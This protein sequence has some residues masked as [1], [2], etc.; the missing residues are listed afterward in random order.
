MPDGCKYIINPGITF[1]DA[2]ER[3]SLLR[4]SIGQKQL[5]IDPWV[6]EL[7]N[8]LTKNNVSDRLFNM[9]D[10][11][12]KHGKNPVDIESTIE[13]LVAYD[14]LIPKDES[15][16]NGERT[17]TIESDRHV[18]NQMVALTAKKAVLDSEK[19]STLGRAFAWIFRVPLIIAINVL[20]FPLLIIAI[21][22]SVAHFK[23]LIDPY[24]TIYYSA[25]CMPILVCV[26]VA[27]GLLHE[28][29][30][31][32]AAVSCGCKVGE[33]GIGI[34]ITSIALYTNMND[35]NISN[36]IDR[37]KIDLGGITVECLILDILIIV[38]FL[39]IT[40]TYISL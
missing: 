5:L 35:S 30:H 3:N 16:N 13:Y 19:A 29:G 38:A 23:L 26:S 17:F 7:I 33:V 24:T 6:Y 21:F 34:Y 37:L 9:N 8:A 36:K 39:P 14:I 4:V 20:F 18:L 15:S 12:Y 40:Y 11:A 1:V 28:C 25:I 2:Q 32:G 10:F 27:I 31:L 22:N